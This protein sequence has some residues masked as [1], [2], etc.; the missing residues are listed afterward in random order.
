MADSGGRNP[1]PPPISA[2]GATL[3]LLPSSALSFVRSVSS[4][5]FSPPPVCCRARGVIAVDRLT[6]NDAPTLEP[7]ANLPFLRMRGS[8][9]GLCQGVP[10]TDKYH[11][12]NAL[13]LHLLSSDI[14]SEE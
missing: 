2:T 12:L 11:L 6:D 10:V 8:L 4:L 5:Y 7:E 14:E 3:R 13:Q 1:F 9:D